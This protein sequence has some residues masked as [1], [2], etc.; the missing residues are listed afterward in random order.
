MHL[1]LLLLLLRVI[2][3]WLETYRLFLQVLDWLLLLSHA[4]SCLLKCAEFLIE[5]HIPLC[6]ILEF[7]LLLFL[8]LNNLNINP[9]LV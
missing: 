3:D 6:Q 5:L 4:L 9:I 8:Q 2:R 1:L 7:L